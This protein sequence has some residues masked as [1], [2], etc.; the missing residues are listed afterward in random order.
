MNMNKK[1]IKALALIRKPI[2][3]EEAFLI[4]CNGGRIRTSDVVSVY[5]SS[6]EIRIETLNTIYITNKKPWFAFDAVYGNLSSSHIIL[7]VRNKRGWG[8]INICPTAFYKCVEMDQCAIETDTAIYC[9]DLIRGEFVMKTF[10]NEP[11]PIIV[12]EKTFLRGGK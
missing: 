1:I 4:L 8:F 3:G 10:F 9:G 6:V 12:D 11:F 5:E 7:N 2:V